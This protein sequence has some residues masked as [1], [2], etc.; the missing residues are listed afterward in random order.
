MEGDI[1]S[2][3]SSWTK[4]VLNAAK[5]SIPR[6]CRKNHVPG[7]TE[8]C[9]NLYQA[10][11]NNPTVQNADKLMDE[12]MKCKRERWH[13][14]VSSVDFTHSSRKAWL[15][16]N[17]LRGRKPKPQ[18]TE[19]SAN[20]ITGQLVDS[21]K[22]SNVDKK[23]GR[24][25]NNELSCLLRQEAESPHLMNDFTFQELLES[26]RLVKCGKAQGPDLIPPDML[27]NLPVTFLKWLLTFFNWC[28]NENKIPKIWRQA[29]VVAIPK[30]NK[31]LNDPKSYRPISLLCTPFKLL[32]RLIL[33]R[34]DPIV[35]PK[36]P[37]TQAGFRREKSTVDQV[38]LLTGRIEKAFQRQEKTGLILVDLTA[39]YDTVWRKEC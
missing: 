22:H 14:A 10:F 38:G 6:G 27:K 26:L 29:L 4:S 20:S 18:Q 24:S 12:L 11:I 21:G 7:W 5:M 19:V 37:K 17:K 2:A 35:D 36:L 1:N 31:P 39:T 25:I 30:P 34:I 33:Q 28:K 15:S 13:E 8:T 9:Q 23:F 32:E 3:Y 16:L